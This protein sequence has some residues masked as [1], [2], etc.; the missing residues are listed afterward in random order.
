[1]VYAKLSQIINNS[2]QSFT[3]FFEHKLVKIG[4]SQ[5][6]LIENDKSEQK[7]LQLIISKILHVFKIS[8]NLS[9]IKINIC[10][11]EYL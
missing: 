5:S 1:V 2:M 7:E 3:A 11:D 6:V 8:I 4:N 9:F 10:E